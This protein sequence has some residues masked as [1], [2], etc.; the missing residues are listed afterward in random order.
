MLGRFRKFTNNHG[1]TGESH[2]F[3][4]ASSLGKECVDNCDSNVGHLCTRTCVLRLSD[5][6]D[7]TEGFIPAHHF[8]P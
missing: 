7:S 1:Y 6:S 8:L 3:F 4:Q 2:G 5:Q